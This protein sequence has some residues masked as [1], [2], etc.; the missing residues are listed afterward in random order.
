MGNLK[1]VEWTC[2]IHRNIYITKMSKIDKLLTI[3]FV[4]KTGR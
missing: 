2:V 4:R 3:L 1:M